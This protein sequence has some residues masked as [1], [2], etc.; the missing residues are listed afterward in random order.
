MARRRERAC[1]LILV[2]LPAQALAGP[3]AVPT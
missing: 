2:I 3:S 1:E